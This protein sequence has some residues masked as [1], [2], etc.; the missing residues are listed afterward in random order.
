MEAEQIKLPQAFMER[1][2]NMLGEEWEAFKT[3]YM[4]DRYQGLRFNPLKVE[5]D[6]EKQK[7]LLRTLRIDNMEPVSWAPNGYYYEEKDRRSETAIRS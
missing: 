6:M 5:T 4:N 2:E 3:C 7:E 1:M